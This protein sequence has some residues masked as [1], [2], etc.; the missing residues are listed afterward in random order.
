MIRRLLKRLALDAFML[1]LILIEFAY[2]LTG[3]TVHE[4]IGL[5]MLM[6]FLLHGG[7][8]WQWIRSVLKGR[9]N[10][11]RV[12]SLSV[13]AL[14]L[15]AS[16]VMM[17]SGIVNSALLFSLT[18]V[19][20][21]LIPREIHTAAA[22]W[23]LILMAIHLGLH[24]KMVMSE[25]RS[26]VGL[27][28]PSRLTAQALRLAAAAIVV[29]G[30]HASFERGVLG[31]LIAYYSFDYWDFEA[32]IAGFFLQY[33]AIVGL[34]AIL[35]YYALPLFKRREQRLRQLALTLLATL[36]GCDKCKCLGRS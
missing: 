11:F 34:Y 21:E 9:Y 16:L 23:F 8:N 18:G 35:A 12:L 33:L 20:L 2:G 3:S 13:N 25:A 7:L 19:E 5:A 17:L 6:L 14:L 27:A 10:A 28:E 36:T 30:V 29:S 22:Y 4:L 1:A 31:K 26:L 15:V 32:S 24:W